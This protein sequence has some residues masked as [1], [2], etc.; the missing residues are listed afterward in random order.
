MSSIVGVGL[1]APSSVYRSLGFSVKSL[2]SIG[3]ILRVKNM[4]LLL[5]EPEPSYPRK[6]LLIQGSSDIS[7]QNIDGLPTQVLTP[8]SHCEEVPTDSHANL[9][10]KAESLVI[11]SP[12]WARTKAAFE[13]LGIKELKAR[14]DIYPGLRLSFFGAGAP[15]NRL[16]LELVAPEEPSVDAADIPAKLWGVTWQVEDDLS[17]ARRAVSHPAFLTESRA[18]VQQGRMIATLKNM[19]DARLA[20]AFISPKNQ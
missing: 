13:S 10:V 2:G 6:T 14:T 15:D 7:L 5:R 3:N 1:C 9:V 12:D 17:A 20:M 8:E 4:Q 19:K 16:I 18:A 11:R